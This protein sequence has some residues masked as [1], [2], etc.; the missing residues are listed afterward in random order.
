MACSDCP[1]LVIATVAAQVQRTL[2]KVRRI[3]AVTT[4]FNRL[5]AQI[6]DKVLDDL[7]GLVDLIPDPPVLD[8]SDIVA[9][10]LC[11]LTPVALEID[12]TLLQ[13]M[14][15]RLV[16]VRVRAILKNESARVIK[17]YNEALR[18]YRSYDLIVTMQRYVTEVYRAMEDAGE[19]ILEYPVNLGRAVLVQQL[20][21]DI[22]NDSQWPFRALVTEIT[23]WSFDGVIPT[24]LDDR[25]AAAVRLVAR[26]EQKLLAWKTVGTVVV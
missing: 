20:C 5:L 12:L 3:K 8:L 1:D 9:Y 22:Y 14:D 10:Y 19:F 17:L 18:T 2:D 25:A 24:G 26:A 16:E 21:P 4:S 15:P 13:N 6:G 11:P 7:N 23:D